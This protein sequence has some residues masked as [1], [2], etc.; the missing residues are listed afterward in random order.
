[1][2]F[3]NVFLNKERFQNKKR[4]KVT[5]I[6]KTFFYIYALKCIISFVFDSTFSFKF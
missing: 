2:N 6:K 5:K 1:V 4:K 3:A